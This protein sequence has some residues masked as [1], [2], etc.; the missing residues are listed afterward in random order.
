M[1]CEFFG[2]EPG[3][4]KPYFQRVG[5]QVFSPLSLFIVPLFTVA[6]TVT[7]AFG[8]D[9][10][11][12]LDRASYWFAVLGAAIVTAF[13]I[14]PLIE[15]RWPLAPI[16]VQGAFLSLAMS[17]VYS[18]ILYLIAHGMTGAKRDNISPFW[19]MVVV[20]FA[21]SMAVL[22]IRRLWESETKPT[23][24]RLI[25][26]FSDQ[27]IKSIYR[28]TVRDHYVDV[29]T[30]RG[31]QTL[32]MR[33]SDAIAELD[34]I[35]GMR[36]HRSHWVACDA[37]DKLETENGR[38]FVVLKDASRVPVSRAYRDAVEKELG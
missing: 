23:L 7:G 5:E 20:V 9:E 13:S 17:I 33:F 32:L 34:E 16:G 38:L 15:N 14:K 6:L 19:L 4:M 37:M 35:K 12:V 10:M 31:M 8:T 25:A 29:F 11:G 30:D 27:N 22:Q 28:V 24:P 36:V 26:R 21:V 3:V 1:S 2:G 18:P